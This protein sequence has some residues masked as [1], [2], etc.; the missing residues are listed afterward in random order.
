MQIILFDYKEMEMIV[1]SYKIK[2]PKID[3]P[4]LSISIPNPLEILEDSV[5]EKIHDVVDDLAQ[6]YKE[7]QGESGNFDDCVLVAASG[8]AA[9]GSAVGGPAGAAI[10]A[11]GG[12][13]A[14]R[15]VCRRLFPE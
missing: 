8:C 2:I 15:L 5:M 12:L 1:L 6:Q 3:I 9:A 7:N 14:A 10:G 13:P 4:D 11:A